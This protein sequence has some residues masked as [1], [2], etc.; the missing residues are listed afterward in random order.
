MRKVIISV[1]VL[2]LGFGVSS[3]EGVYAAKIEGGKPSPR[4]KMRFTTEAKSTEHE[5]AMD[6]LLIENEYA[7]LQAIRSNQAQ[8]TIDKTQADAAEGIVENNFAREVTLLQKKIQ[9]KR[10]PTRAAEVKLGKKEF[11][12]GATLEGFSPS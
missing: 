2:V 12:E 5:L 11:L 10:A 9:G 8:G 6:K 3:F 7:A 4:G 1:S